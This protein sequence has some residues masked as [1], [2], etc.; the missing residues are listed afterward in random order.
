MTA[1]A[2]DMA[3][4][5]IDVEALNKRYAEERAKR[6]RGDA[7]A[8]YARLEGKFANFD[9]DIYAD[10]NFTRAAVDEQLDVLIIGGGFAGLLAAIRLRERGIDNFRIVEKGADVGGTWYW[11]RY[12]GAASDVEAYIYMPML[13][14]LGYLPKTK[15]APAPEIQAH[16]QMLAQRYDLYPKALFQTKVTG[17]VKWDE[18]SSR[19]TVTTDRGDRISTRFLLSCTG[20]Y[21]T[22]KLPNIPGVESFEGHAFHTSR[23]DYD[24]TGG[25]SLGGLDKL[26]DKVVGVIGTGATAVQCIPHLAQAAKHLYVFQRTPSSVDV[27][28]QKKTDPEWA[29]SLKPGWQWERTKNFTAATAGE[30]VAEDLVDD[31]WTDII[32]NIAAPTGGDGEVSPDLALSGLKKMELARRRIDSIVEDKATAE[33]L[34][35]YYAYFCKRPCFHDEYLPVFNQPNVTL[36]D[37]KGLGVERITAKGAVVD[38]KEYPVDCLVYAT[39]FEFMTD[40]VKQTGY[41]LVGRDGRKLSEHWSH[42]TRTLWGIQTSGFPNFFLMALNQAGVGV[43]YVHMAT[44]QTAHFA[45]VIDECLKKGIASVEVTEEAE[46]AWVQEVL[47]AAEGGRNAFLES[48]TPSHYN[49]E[50]KRAESARLNDLY[51]GGPGEYVKRIEAWRADGSMPGFH[52]KHAA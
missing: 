41:D 16:C 32:R 31:G 1:D 15:Y 44:E 51:A 22:P 17:E 28:N 11:N 8:Q 29:K 6:L 7:N 20:T 36:V 5:E 46:D 37:T 40:F 30:P 18:A 21:D 49:H 9:H 4:I 25:N 48:C 34:K 24:Y 35:P 10:P 47:T 27:R 3:N 50:G 45:H 38:G 13:E 12:P 43:N 23:W 42:G 26:G 2:N 14:E 52:V 33:A 19:W 39:G